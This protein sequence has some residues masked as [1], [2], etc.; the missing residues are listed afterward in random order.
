MIKIF[1]LTTHVLI[2]MSFFLVGKTQA[3]CR[4]LKLQLLPD[5]I[6]LVD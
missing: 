4:N 2:F 1:S 5:L 3:S 6:P